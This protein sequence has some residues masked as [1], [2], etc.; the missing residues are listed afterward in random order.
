MG[1]ETVYQIHEQL[2]AKWVIIDYL[3]VSKKKE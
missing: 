1:K 2:V 3:H